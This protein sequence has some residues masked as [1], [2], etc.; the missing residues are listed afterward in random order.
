[1]RVAA[2]QD[3]SARHAQD[4]LPGVRGRLHRGGGRPLRLLAGDGPD[5]ALQLLLRDPDDL[6]GEAGGVGEG[7]DGGLLADE[8][9]GA[10]ALLPGIP[11]VRQEV[12]S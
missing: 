10:G 1:M 9:H 5:G 4:G 2:D 8:Q 11:G 3:Q 12:Q 6:G 7:E